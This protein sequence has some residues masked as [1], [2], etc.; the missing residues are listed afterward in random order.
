MSARGRFSSFFS[1]AFLLYVAIA[2]RLATGT[3]SGVY[4]CMCAIGLTTR[5][6][7]KIDVHQTFKVYE[8]NVF[9]IRAS[10]PFTVRM[11]VLRIY[12]YFENFPIFLFSS[13]FLSFW[14]LLLRA[15]SFLFGI[16]VM[17]YSCDR[18]TYIYIMIWCSERK[19]KLFIF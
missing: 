17:K 4:L 7:K 19:K 13:F 3:W 12:D 5:L 11:P 2:M 10:V 1:F 9:R 6:H 15:R 14:H 8:W 18:I 16:Y